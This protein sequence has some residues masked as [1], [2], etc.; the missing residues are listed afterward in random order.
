M[1]GLNKTSIA[2]LLASFAGN[3]LANSNHIQGKT[4][5]IADPCADISRPATLH[6]ASAPS[7]QF[8]DAGR[9]WA[10][11]SMGGH[12]YVN[13]SDDKAKSF[14]A[15]VVVNL[16]PETISAHGENRPKIAVDKSGRIYVSWTMPLEKRF[17][18][19]IRFS[20]S[21]DGG[22]HFSEPVIVNDNL[23]ITGHRFD[24][25]G[26]ADNGNV[27]LAWI[28]KRDRHK[29][30][31][32]GKK[33]HGAAIY[34]AYSN[35]AG[36]TFQPNQKIIDHSCECCRVIVDVDNNNLPVILWRNIFGKN[37]RDHAL[38]NFSDETRFSEPE[39]VSFDNWQLDACP[40]HGPD[41]HIAEN[42]EYHL[43]WFNNA[44]ERHGLFYARRNIDGA[45]TEP[46]NFG[47]YQAAASH[48]SVLS[49]KA[50]VWLTWKEF[51][52]K[53]T[54][55]WMKYSKD[56]GKLWSAAKKISS[57][58]KDADYPFLLKDKHS[59]FI[60]WHI[61]SEGFKLIPV[62]KIE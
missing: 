12:V 46:L 58:T 43:A 57:T 56:N 37:I 31:Q 17:T 1:S 42:N 10:A 61:K 4:V 21:N 60:Q 19:H 20:V 3:V 55:I 39:R 50:N 35:D 44:P 6:C 13:Y 16:K 49:D 59:V 11:W 15:P 38:V 24:A 22:E 36:K 14:S 30:E 48:P 54:S 26:V 45:Y 53:E 32:Q 41:M 8:D 27:Y 23:D 28:D 62:S 47:N 34:Y 51:D 9:L 33:Y 25:L 7:A 18:G 29:A 5:N 40:H 2:L 52:G